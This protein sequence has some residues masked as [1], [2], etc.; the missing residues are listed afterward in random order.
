MVC[1]WMPTAT[2]MPPCSI[3]A[4]SSSSIGTVCPL[5]GQ[6]LIPGRDNG[7]FLLTTSMAF[8]PGTNEI[9]LVATDGDGTHGATV[10]RTFGF[11]KAATPLSHQ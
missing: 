7:R 1:G 11:A 2:S 8:K 5:A 4:A 6:I 10:F 3:K 9:Y